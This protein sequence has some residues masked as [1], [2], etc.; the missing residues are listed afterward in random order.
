MHSA[1]G[2]GLG[3]VTLETLHGTVIMNEFFESEG[4]V[5]LRGHRYQL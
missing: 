1:G 2:L 4:Q 5:L 3:V